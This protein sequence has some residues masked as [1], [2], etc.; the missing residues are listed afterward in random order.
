M[1]A[2]EPDDLPEPPAAATDLRARLVYVLGQV[3]VV[4]AG[5][6]VYF[7][8]RGL[9][10]GSVDQAQDHAREIMRFEQVI[11]LDHESA[12]QGL[13]ITS[14]AL[15]T[16]ANWVYIWGHWPVIV[17]TMSWLVVAHRREFARLRDAM[18]VS[19]ALGMAIFAS[20]PV[21]PP[22][23][24][25]LGFVDTVSNRSESYRVLQPPAFVNQYAAMPSLH[26]GW[27]LLVGMAIVS[28]ASCLALKVVGVVMPA[29]MALAVV[30]TAN[31]F[32]VD[33]VAGTALVLAGHAVA[34]WLERRRE[35]PRV[36]AP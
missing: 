32:I 21:A 2:P 12:L 7:R 30:A 28:A 15:E 26:A 27:D 29:L 13:V 10:E 31:H 35:R 16:A 20:Y 14:G 34:L 33:V 22:R 6:F 9:T 3:G 5:I 4:V 36:A 23:L 19:G 11:G 8:V 1:P 18:I 17:A 25:G 24:A